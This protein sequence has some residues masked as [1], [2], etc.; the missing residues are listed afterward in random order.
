MRPYGLA[1]GF[2]ERKISGSIRARGRRANIINLAPGRRPCFSHRPL[3]G[4]ID[5]TPFILRRNL[6]VDLAKLRR[7]MLLALNRRGRLAH[8]HGRFTFDAPR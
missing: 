5:H 4:K 7:P 3:G 2:C 8:V 1:R 6:A